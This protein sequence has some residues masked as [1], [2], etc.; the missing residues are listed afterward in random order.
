MSSVL[1]STSL[2]FQYALEFKPVNGYFLVPIHM[3]R[4]Y[5]DAKSYRV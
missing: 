1:K 4:L 3:I 2:G 5:L